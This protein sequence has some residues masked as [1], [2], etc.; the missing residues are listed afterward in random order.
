MRKLLHAPIIFIITLCLCIVGGIGIARAQDVHSGT[1]IH[2]PSGKIVNGSYFAAGRSVDIAGTVNGDVICGAQTLTISGTVRGDVVCGAQTVTITG[3]VIGSVRVAAQTT[4]LSGPIG[5]SASVTG[6]NL[7]LGGKSSVGNDLSFAGSSLT[8]DGSVGRDVV[9]SATAMTVG[10]KIDR[11][12]KA[13]TNNL[14]I[15]DAAIVGG[16]V[17]YKSANKAHIANGAQVSNVQQTVPV[18]N[19]QAQKASHW[20]GLAL[21]G[22]ALAALFCSFILVLLLPRFFWAVSQEAVTRF[23]WVLLAGFITGIVLPVVGLLAF[24]TILGIPLGIVILGVGI[25]LMLLA[26]PVAA[27]YLGRLLFH[28]LLKWTDNAIFL[29][30]LGAIVLLLLLAIPLINILVWVLMEWI[31]VGSMVLALLRRLGKPRYHLGQ[32]KNIV[33][34]D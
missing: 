2:V 12:V 31:G 20:F 19:K 32:Q 5:R 16:T 8:V 18:N 17:W 33:T 1:N 14:K 4:N 13:T 24:I 28:R 9:A 34:V 3:N 11:N 10:G 6:Q 22:Y 21:L 7:D 29:M 30:L 27:F 23:G 26:F 25:L 15:N